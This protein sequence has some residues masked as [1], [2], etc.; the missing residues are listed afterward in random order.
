MNKTDIRAQRS[1][2]T[3]MRCPYCQPEEELVPKD[4]AH[5]YCLRCGF[6]S[7]AAPVAEPKQRLAKG[8]L[9]RCPLCFSEVETDE[10]RTTA[11]LIRDRSPAFER[12]DETARQRDELEHNLRHQAKLNGQASMQIEALETQ[13]DQIDAELCEVRKQ[14]H[15]EQVAASLQKAKLEQQREE[16]YRSHD[17]L[18]R[19]AQRF[20]AH[21]RNRIADGPLMTDDEC[22]SALSDVM[23]SISRGA[24]FEGSL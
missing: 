21:L 3:W 18:F 15:L 4:A 12:A 9:W 10:N 8:Q 1:I 16:L 22:L 24:K 14:R 5:I 20:E 13:R 23:G 11:K 2:I 7:E 6:T 17:Q 19:I